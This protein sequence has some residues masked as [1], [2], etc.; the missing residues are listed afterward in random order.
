MLEFPE[1]V[2][3]NQSLKPIL[4]AC[5]SHLRPS[6]LPFFLKSYTYTCRDDF[7]ECFTL[8]SAHCYHLLSPL[9]QSF[10]L[11]FHQSQGCELLS[12]VLPPWCWT[13][14]RQESQH[15]LFFPEL[16]FCDHW[17]FASP[18]HC[19]ESFYSPP[20]SR[21]RNFPSGSKP[22]FF[23]RY[24]PRKHIVLHI[25][26]FERRPKKFALLSSF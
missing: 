10:L 15:S 24:S 3:T 5:D 23:L 2:Q 25:Y 9:I 1:F 26:Q 20:L 7:E 19:P 8:L 4:L 17:W 22:E 16:S 11:H 21:G 18:A 12:R 14:S 13:G 6:E